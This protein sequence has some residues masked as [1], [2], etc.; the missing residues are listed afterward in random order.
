MKVSSIPTFQHGGF[1]I[2][3]PW[4][5]CGADWNEVSPKTYGF[6]QDPRNP[7]RLRLQVPGQLGYFQLSPVFGDMVTPDVTVYSRHTA[8]GLNTWSATVAEI[9][10][11][12]EA[13]DEEPPEPMTQ[14]HYLRNGGSRCPFCGSDEVA[15]T[16]TIQAEASKAWQDIECSACGKKWQDEY[17]LT[18][19]STEHVEQDGEEE[20]C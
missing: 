8:D 15:G 17:K 6:V 18:G 20:G 10:Q 2:V 11:A 1:D 16:S 7:H 4:R 5:D 13:A 9:D 12:V 14:E 19:Y 3:R